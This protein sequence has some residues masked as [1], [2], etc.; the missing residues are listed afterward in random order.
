MGF[1]ESCVTSHI[2]WEAPYFWITSL[3]LDFPSVLE[4]FLVSAVIV[5]TGGGPRLSSLLLHASLSCAAHLP[6]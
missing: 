2:A 4:G 5:G 1:L 3:D 6:S